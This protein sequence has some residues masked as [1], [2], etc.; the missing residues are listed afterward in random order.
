MVFPEQT[1]HYGSL[2][3]GKALAAMGKTAFIAATRHCRKTILLA[4]SRRVD[5][6]SQIQKGEV[7]ELCP[8]LVSVGTSSMTIV[9]ELNAKNLQ[10]GKRRSC[11]QG[12]STMVAVDDQ[13]HPIHAK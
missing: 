11:G 12:E 6:T 7:M 10:T 1:G 3:G 2:Y 4:A 13:N 5:F 8:Q 9:V